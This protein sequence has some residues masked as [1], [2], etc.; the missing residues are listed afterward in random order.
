MEAERERIATELRS[1]GKEVAEGI[2]ADA[3]RQKAIIVANAYKQ[4]EIIRGEGDQKAAD[5]Y[6]KAYNQ[7][8]DF[9]QFYRSLN[10]YQHAFNKPNDILVL[11]PEG[12]FFK[13]F[14]NPQGKSS[15]K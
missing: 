15:E 1:Q 10:A 4:A 12:S 14:T 9:Y 8:P 13:Y 2:R 5:V 6:A 11:Q 3:D 7:D